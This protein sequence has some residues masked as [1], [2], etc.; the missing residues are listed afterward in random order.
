MDG[1]PPANV[2]Q[3]KMSEI[4][5]AGT[6]IFKVTRGRFARLADLA[7][8]VLLF[9]VAT[10]GLPSVRSVQA[11]SHPAPAHRVGQIDSTG[12]SPVGGLTCN[13]SE[14]IGRLQQTVSATARGVSVRPVT[15]QWRHCRDQHV[16]DQQKGPTPQVVPR[17]VGGGMYPAARSARISAARLPTRV[18]FHPFADPM[19]PILAAQV[20]CTSLRMCSESHR[21][22][23]AVAG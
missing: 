22:R 1:C 15:P 11:S 16:F 8:R 4:A 10:A 9:F 21:R 5:P 3:S 23:G 14:T 18:K 20:A 12:G 2:S 19:W 6:L 17:F 7:L 13:G